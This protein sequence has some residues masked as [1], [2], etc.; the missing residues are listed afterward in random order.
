MTTPD[1]STPWVPLWPRKAPVPVPTP[2]NGKWLQAVGGAC[3]WS[4]L[5]PLGTPD[6]AWKVLGV[7]VAFQNGWTNYGASN[8][9][10]PAR[11]RKTSDG[12]VM[13]SGLITGGTS[14]IAFT[15]P[16]GYRIPTDRWVIFFTATAADA[17]GYAVQID[18]DGSVYGIDYVY[19]VLDGVM[20]YAE[21]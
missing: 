16:V 20:F 18:G 5:P 9:Y 8:P 3:V 2:V 15:L 10:N 1:T 21:A 13:L 17:P 19:T 14:Q 12:L 11:F 4:D 6:T 7:D